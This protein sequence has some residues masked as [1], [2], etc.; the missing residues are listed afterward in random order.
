MLGVLTQLFS[1]L[2]YPISLFPKSIGWISYILP[3]SYAF[4]AIRRIAISGEGFSNKNVM[5]DVIVL[6]AF[7]VCSSIIGLK[8]FRR[9]LSKTERTTGFSSLV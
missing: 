2:Y 8:L 4:D 6:F 9:A 5:T 3:H 7:T 1:G